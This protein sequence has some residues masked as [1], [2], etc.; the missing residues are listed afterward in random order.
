MRPNPD[1]DLDDRDA[2]IDF[3][4]LDSVFALESPNT[5]VLS[6]VEGTNVRDEAENLAVW[7]RTKVLGRNHPGG[8]ASGTDKSCST[9]GT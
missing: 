3:P 1:N 9:R 6:E 4:C 8:V 7:A 5:E 2:M